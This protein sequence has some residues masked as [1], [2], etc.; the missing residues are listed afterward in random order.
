MMLNPLAAYSGQ[1]LSLGVLG[2]VPVTV[3]QTI[4]EGRLDTEIEAGSR[5]SDGLA[6]RWPLSI[7]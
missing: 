7:K 2:T 3:P 6:R 1:R 4:T 5:S